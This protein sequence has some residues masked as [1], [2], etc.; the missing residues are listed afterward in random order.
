MGFGS[1]DNQLHIANKSG[2]NLYVVVTPNKDWVWGDVG[3]TVVTSLFSGGAT[4][5]TAINSLSKLQKIIALVKLCL[6]N[7]AVQAVK[8]GALSYKINANIGREIVHPLKERAHA[9]REEIMAFL[10]REAVVIKPGEFKQVNNEKNYNPL[11]MITPSGWG[12]LFGAS[13]CTVFVITESLSRSA[14]FHTN[15]DWSWIV[16]PNMVVRSKYGHIWEE[17][18]KEGYYRFSQSDRI[19]AGQF[20]QPNES[21]SSPNKDYDFVYQEDGNAVVY[22]RD[23]PADQTAIWSTDT[24]RQAAWRTYM[25]EDG[26]FVVYKQEGVPA[27]ASGVHGNDPKYEGCSLVLQDDGRLVIYNKDNVEI[28]A[29]SK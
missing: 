7:P 19:M 12:G 15:S 24:H 17:E 25:Q 14:L 10:K 11:R 22:K 29:S 9:A 6:N 23:R 2:E 13:D 27:W 21:I 18:L 26:N 16:Q 20:L 1:L 5:A 28:W 8:Y 3:F 4:G